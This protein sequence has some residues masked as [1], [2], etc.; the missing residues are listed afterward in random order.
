[1]NDKTAVNNSAFYYSINMLR[2]LLG[3]K[4]ITEDEYKR[5]SAISAGH[6]GVKNL[7]V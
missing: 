2:L 1:M 7:C 4:L 3:M 6:Y 5:I